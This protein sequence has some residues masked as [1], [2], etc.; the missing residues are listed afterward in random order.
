MALVNQIGELQIVPASLDDLEAILAI[1]QESF[2]VPWTRKAFE[3]EL[4]GNEFSVTLVARKMISDESSSP[5]Y[6]LSLRVG[7][8]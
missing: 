7:G 8:I 6:C 5:N 1:E 3:A 2:A 4:V